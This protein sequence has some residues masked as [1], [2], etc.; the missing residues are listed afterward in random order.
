M[1]IIPVI[2]YMQGD[3]VLA[4]KGE[5]DY[6][7]PIESKLCESSSLQDI[8]ANLLTLAPFDCIYIADLDSIHCKSFKPDLWPQLCNA[9]PHI[10]F[11]L[12]IG[13]YVS[14]WSNIMQ[15]VP[16]ARPIV[17]SESIASVTNLKI[18]L[19]ILNNYN[20]LLSIDIKD[21]NV[22]GPEDLFDS[23]TIW[24][25]DIIILPLSHVG[26]HE[27]PAIDLVETYIQ[28]LS[29]FNIFTGGGIRN[30]QDLE[31]LDQLGISGALLASC[32]HTGSVTSQHM[33]NFIE[34]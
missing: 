17:G 34:G 4:I 13:K 7:L 21:Q 3:V 5:R 14:Q 1:K 20:P 23:M 15:S 10:E 29:E 31:K 26:S 30:E 12:D 32:L 33:Y 24:P 19:R 16:N 27:G 6:Y 9:Y 28:Q 25:K 2:D 22:L 18:I 8:I 11:W